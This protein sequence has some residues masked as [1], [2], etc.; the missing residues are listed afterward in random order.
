MRKRSLPLVTLDSRVDPSIP[1]V[2]FRDEE[3][4]SDLMARILARGF[5][6]LH[7]LTFPPAR[8]ELRGNAGSRPLTRRLRGFRAALATAPLLSPL[9]QPVPVLA[10]AERPCPFPRGLRRKKTIEPPSAEAEQGPRP[11]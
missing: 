8:Q 1:S 2:T 5:R 6:R 4:A 11:F 9:R 10:Q 3:G 7:I